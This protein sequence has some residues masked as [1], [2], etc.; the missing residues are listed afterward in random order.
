MSKSVKTY[1]LGIRHH[2]VGSTARLL[3]VLDQLKPTKVLIEGASDCSEL[4]PLLA[5][6]QMKPPVALLAYATE[7]PDLHFYYPFTEFSPEYQA[8]LWAV[9]NKA[10]VAFIDL[11]V[12]VKLAKNLQEIELAKQAEQEQ[13]ENQ[14][15][16]QIDTLNEDPTINEQDG[17]NHDSGFDEPSQELSHDKKL[18]LQLSHDPIKI[19]A[20]LA[21]YDDGEDWWHD[22][23]EQN[24]PTGILSQDLAVF[25]SVA[26]AMLLL[27]QRLIEHGDIAQSDIEREAY[28]RQ[29]IASVQKS[30]NDDD[31]IVVVCGAWHVPALDPTLSSQLTDKDDKAFN[32]SQKNDTAIIKALPKKLASSKVKTTWIPWTSPR[33]ASQSGYG[34]GVKSPM[35]Y[36]HLWQN[37]HRNDMVEHWLT[38]VAQALREQGQVVS[39]ASV[40]EAV[41]LSQS[42]ASVRNRPSVGFEELTESAISCLCFGEPILW[43]QI[44]NN[45]LLGNQVGQIPDDMPLAPLLEDLQRLQKQTKLAPES[46]AKEISLDLRSDAGL[47]KSHLLHRLRI[48]GVNWGKMLDSGSSRG[49]FREKWLLEWQPE[50]AVE[51]VENLVYG[52]TIEQASNNKLAETMTHTQQ[53]SE[54]VKDVQKALQASLPHATDV[55]LQRLGILA[56]QT[57]STDELLGS[58][59]PLIHLERYGTARAMAL[60]QVGELVRQLTI[61]TSVALPYAL[62]QIDNDVAEQYHKRIKDTHHALVLGELDEDVM[63]VWWQAI[64]EIA[65]SLHNKHQMTHTHSLLIGLCNRLLYQDDKI[66]SQSLEDTLQKA[67]SP[68]IATA[69]SAQFFAGFF[70]GATQNLL[71][72]DVLLNVV[73][74]WLIGLEGDEFV[75]Y[76]PLFRRVFASL[77]PLER[78]HLLERVTQGKQRQSDYLPNADNYPLWQQQFSVLQKLLNGDKHWASL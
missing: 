44:E 71:F 5:H 2:G 32:F 77:D 30:A 36:Q 58:L 12:A 31:V 68:A 55:G 41:R 72:D 74:H 7:S 4:L 6:R 54:L 67:L 63:A 28:M 27:R 56:N 16:S 59:S 13:P 11:P 29:Q 64:G 34:A 15:E 22:V 18:A 60:E 24:H 73:K 33:L 78:K 49:T 25:S 9:K 17:D 45:L 26:N 57:D 1:Y 37:R 35:W 46:L 66:S 10:N 3:S 76:L 48:L 40:I 65:Q 62:R 52:N 19:L 38:K 42:L 8:S 69:E 14:P 20:N 51:L 39:T 53:L 70:Q 21:G 43:R 50:F 75:E 61:K 23:I 47:K